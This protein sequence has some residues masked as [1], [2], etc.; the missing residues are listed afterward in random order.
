[1]AIRNRPPILGLNRA[2][3]NIRRQPS[4]QMR[5]FR[6]IDGV[7]GWLAWSV[8]LYHI[9]L[10]TA[11]DQWK[12]VVAYIHLLD[13][14]SVPCFIIISGF[15]ITHL[16]LERKERYFPYI[17]RRFLRI[18]PAYICCLALGCVATY[19]HFAAF[20]GHPWGD[21]V[22]Q[23]EILQAE[24]AGSHGAELGWH[25]LAHL[26][27]LHGLISNNVLPVSQYMFLGP[28]WSLSLEW[29]F[30]LLAPLIIFWVR[31]PPGK[32]MVSLAAVAALAAYQRGW[33]GAFGDPSS[34]PGAG[35]YFAAGIGS[36]LVYPKLP[37]LSAY[38]TVGVI[39]AGGFVILAR[40]LLPF[41]MWIAFIAWLRVEHPT[42]G[43]RHGVD[44]CLDVA[45]N[46]KIARYLGKRSYSTYLVHEPIIHTIV[47]MCI[48]LFSLGIAATVGVM[49]VTVPLITWAMSGLLWRYVEEPAID[50]GKRRF[51]DLD[52]GGANNVGVRARTGTMT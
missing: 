34:L 25:L 22:P 45:F 46:S 42:D 23:P 31:T 18:Y 19:L 40:P 26:T 39:L 47:Y 16:L 36:R 49:F 20:A 38:P 35:L 1:M 27:M 7:R 43:V 17:A 44:R 5:H 10:L 51:R 13:Y 30:Y 2:D 48:K 21:Y 4:Q 8:V 28:A 12:P 29:Q 11:A 33:F 37:T 6:S 9:L 32:I 24:L 50:F 3:L 15:V 52:A 14:V 41:V